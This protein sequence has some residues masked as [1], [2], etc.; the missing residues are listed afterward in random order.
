MKTK[1]RPPKSS[2]AK[3]AHHISDEAVSA[4]TGKNWAEWFQILDRFGAERM[5]HREIAAHLYHKAG[6]N[7][8]WSQM[9]AV[10]YERARHLRALHQQATGY[11]ASTSAVLPFSR[12]ALYMAWS[13]EKTRTGWL[14]KKRIRISTATPGRS[15]RI[16]LSGGKEI[17]SVNF[18][19][20]GKGK[21]QIVIDHMRLRD[22]SAVTISKSFWKGRLKK[23][24]VQL[25]GIRPGKN[26]NR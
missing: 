17:V 20:K 18:R 6:A 5:S 9:I 2:S 23:L 10:I 3:P 25:S 14:G 15:M 16:A 24:A 26:H 21:T 19:A 22:A 12:K 7:A 8:W 11:S 1:P 4:R 13:D